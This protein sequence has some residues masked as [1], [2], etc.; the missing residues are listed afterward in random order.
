MRIYDLARRMIELSGLSLRNVD[1]PQGDIEIAVTG[2]RPGEKLF[3][4]L[5]IG[6]NPQ[7]TV[8]PRIMKADEDFLPLNLLT[9]KLDV[10][11]N[12]IDHHDIQALRL[13]LKELVSGYVPQAEVVDWVVM[14]GSGK[15][16]P[17]TL[18]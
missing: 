4:E 6:D 15:F 14:A 18:H 17:Q 16:Q 5:L 1:D 13:M 12:T 10:L 2:L 11:K 9:E 8:H 7:A 3:E